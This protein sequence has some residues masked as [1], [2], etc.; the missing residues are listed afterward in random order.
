MLR[1][2]G[3]QKILLGKNVCLFWLL[4]ENVTVL[5]IHKAWWVNSQTMLAAGQERWD[6]SLFSVFPAL[7]R[8]SQNPLSPHSATARGLLEES[9]GKAIG[10]EAQ[11]WIAQT[12][13]EVWAVGEDLLTS[14]KDGFCLIDSGE[15]QRFADPV[16]SLSIVTCSCDACKH[17]QPHLTVWHCSILSQSSPYPGE[18]V[19]W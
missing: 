9:S 15:I 5:M 11:V 3:M 4:T 17:H 1:E 7:L 18:V 12:W 19:W 6:C 13:V 2:I 16:L 10:R 14:A 8:G